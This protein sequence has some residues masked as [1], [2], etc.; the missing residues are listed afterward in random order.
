MKGFISTLAYEFTFRYSHSQHTTSLWVATV[1]SAT[2][3]SRP[4]PGGPPGLSSILHRS[5][6]WKNCFHQIVPAC[7]FVLACLVA[8]RKWWSNIFTQPKSWPSAP[9]FPRE[10]VAISNF[11]LR[12]LFTVYTCQAHSKGLSLFTK[13][14]R[15]V[16]RKLAYEISGLMFLF[17]NQ[18]DRWRF[19]CRRNTSG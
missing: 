15:D 16:Q 3:S 13:S 7:L 1:H 5:K 2:H 17:L 14:G 6:F 9:F 11:A 18:T 12:T 8:S 4:H 10:Y 19:Y